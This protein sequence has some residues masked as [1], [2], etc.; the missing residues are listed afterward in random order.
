MLTNV[1]KFDAMF[2]VVGTPCSDEDFA[3]EMATLVKSNCG[4][5]KELTKNLALATASLEFKFGVTNRLTICNSSGEIEDGNY[6]S[7]KIANIFSKIAVLCNA[8]WNLSSSTI[9]RMQF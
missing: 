9:C 3:K 1:S 6:F 2:P 5:G 7:N 8:S 4:T